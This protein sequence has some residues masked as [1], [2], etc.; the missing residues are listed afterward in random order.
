[1]TSAFLSTSIIPRVDL[2]VLRRD[3][4]D[5]FSL[6]LQAGDGTPYDLSRVQVC[7]SVWKKTGGVS[8]ELVTTINVEEKEPLSAGI[9]RLWLT[10]SQTA[11]I[12]DAYGTVDSPGGVFF[13]NAY[14][15][16]NS[17]ALLSPLIWDVR[18]E[19]QE[20]SSN[21]LSVASGAFI[22]Q[23]NHGL[24][25]A[26]RVVF[27]GTTSSGINFN[28]TSA[29]IYS[30]LTDISYLAPYSF[31]IPSLS[32]VTSSGIGGAVYRLKQDTVVAG[33]VLVGTTVSN[34]FP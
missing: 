22:T 10:S 34:C 6:L 17:T 12:W 14:S 4:F 1:M 9:I 27:S 21:L 5:G 32:G 30:G 29:T 18:I 28:N 31:T 7:A 8:Y 3:Y 26:D 25:S 19:N 2:Y 23:T 15:E 20:Y 11:A 33:N 13:P 24:A 16:N